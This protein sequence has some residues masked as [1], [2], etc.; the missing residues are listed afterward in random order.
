MKVYEFRK[1][2]KTH[3]NKALA[4][5][6]Y[7]ERGGMIYKLESFGPISTGLKDLAITNL[8]RKGKNFTMDAEVIEK[9]KECLNGH[10]ADENGKCLT[11]GCKYG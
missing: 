10:L 7:I 3:F 8:K 5:P 2:L 9:I 11:K 6:V 4:E 1:D